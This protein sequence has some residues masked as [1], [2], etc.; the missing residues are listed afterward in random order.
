MNIPARYCTGYLGDVG[1]PPPWPAGDFAAW[2][3][4]YLGGRWLTFDPRNNVPRRARV[5]MASGRDASDVAAF[6]DHL[7]HDGDRMLFD[8]QMLVLGLIYKWRERKGFEVT[9]EKRDYEARRD[10]LLGDQRGAPT[11][12]L[13]ARSSKSNLVGGANVPITGFGS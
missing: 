9:N 8:F 4:V 10:K 13:T 11:L 12:S 7:E 2:M 1:T 3:E 5:L 6:R